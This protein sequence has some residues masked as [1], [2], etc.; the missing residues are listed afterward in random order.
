MINVLSLFDGISCGQIALNNLGLKYNNYFS[1]EI[2]SEAIGITQTHFPKTIQLGDVRNLKA[3]TLPNIH[4]LLAGSP[5][6]GFSHAGKK[7][8]FDDKRSC[9]FFELVRLIKEIKPKYFMIEN[10]VMKKEWQNK[11]SEILQVDPHMIDSA[12][13]SAQQRKRLYWT[14]FELPCV[15]KLIHNKITIDDVLEDQVEEKYF[16]DDVKKN[17]ILKKEEKKSYFKTI[18]FNEGFPLVVNDCQTINKNQNGRRIRPKHSKCFTLTT[19]DRHGILK[20]EK[21]RKLTPKE[22]EKLQ[23]LPE[24][25]TLGFSDTSRYRMIGNGW[26]VKTIEYILSNVK[27]KLSD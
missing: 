13:F 5:C 6:Q 26:N 27:E 12:N 18:D 15:D 4:L 22:C 19:R 7:L 11:I 17:I 1:C 3:D 9:L 21:L 2:D 14:N 25:Y 8:N 24:N 23:T 10:V 16:I 20:N